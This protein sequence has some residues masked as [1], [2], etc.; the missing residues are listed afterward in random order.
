MYFDVTMPITLFAAVLVAMFLNDKVEQKLKGVFEGKEFRNRDALL[1]VASIGVTV[2]IVI[3]IPQLAIMTLF[4]FSYSMVLFIFGYLFSNMRKGRAT[5]SLAAFI[6]VGLILSAAELFVFRNSRYSVYGFV[7]FIV[8]SALVFAALLYDRVRTTVGERWYLAV[9][10]PALFIGLY[11]FF[12]DTL[13]WFPYLLDSYAL[14]F[15]VLI[16]L[17]LSSMFKW[18]TMLLFVTAL[19]VVDIILVLFTGTMVSAARTV[20]ALKLPILV[21]LPTVPTIQFRGYELYMSLGLGDFFFAGLLAI[22]TIKRYGRKTAVF[23]LIAMAISFFIYETY[24]LNFEVQAF[25]GTLMIICGW[26]PVAAMAE[27]VRR[28]SR[29]S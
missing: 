8:F 14:V 21:S 18:S 5:V 13:I 26:L 1:L 19:T 12:S 2:S 3:F 11:F 16:I 20:S 10:P 24:L 7:V 22:Q 23:A 9:L 4:L 17:Y 29:P 25:P 15:A 27:I 6:V 28:R